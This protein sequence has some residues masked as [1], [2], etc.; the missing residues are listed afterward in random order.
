M[1]K[2]GSSALS[3]LLKALAAILIV[4]VT[5]SVLVEYRDYFPPNFESDFLRGRETYFWGHY[6]LAFFTHIV[7]GPAALILG[8]I[9][10]SERFRRSFPFWH[11]RLGRIQV[12]L[13]SLLVTPSGLWMARSM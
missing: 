3:R 12:A 10:I 6:H 9:L 13:V 4:K 8:A 5:L 7:S 11:R 2:L 1:P